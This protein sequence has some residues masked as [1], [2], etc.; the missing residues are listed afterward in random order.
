MSKLFY[1]AGVKT[2]MIDFINAT[3]SQFAALAAACPPASSPFL[4]RILPGCPLES[5]VHGRRWHLLLG[6]RFVK[7][8]GKEVDA[9]CG[10]YHWLVSTYR[11]QVVYNAAKG[12]QPTPS[13][14][15]SLDDSQPIEWIAPLSKANL[16]ESHF[17]AYGNQASVG[18]AYGDV[19]LVAHVI[20]AEDRGL[21]ERTEEEKVEE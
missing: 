8:R 15:R 6:E 12:P 4:S 13:W 17:L 20:S 2:A 18:Y 16:F 1:P 9:D 21:V 7:F 19:C 14:R 11:A 5:G 3:D 10:L